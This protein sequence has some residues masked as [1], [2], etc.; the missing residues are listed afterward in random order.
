MTRSQRR[1]GV[2]L[3]LGF[4]LAPLCAE[5]PKTSTYRGQVVPLAAVLAEAGVKLD[6]D[7]AA[8]WLALKTD[9]GK[10]YPLVNDAGARMFFKDAAL[11][12]R[13]M[14][15]TGRL[16]AGS[17]LQ[18]VAAQSVRDGKLHDLY[19]WCDI[20]TI[21]TYQPGICECCGQPIERREEPARVR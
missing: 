15:L 20:C 1:V 14:S 17:F 3:A 6:S 4:S 13:P 21:R 9:D 8:Q 2:V 10:V 7:A 12:K 11:L 18:V 5:E 16:V 19:Y